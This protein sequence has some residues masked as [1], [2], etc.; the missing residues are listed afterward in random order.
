CRRRGEALAIEVWDTG[1][2]IAEADQRLIFEEFRRLGNGGQGLGLGLA[3]A[4]RIARLLGHR[5]SLRSTPGRG[6]CFAIAVPLAASAQRRPQ[7][8]G[9]APRAPRARV[10][11]VDNDPAVLKAMQAL[12]EGWH[13]EVLAARSPEEA[14]IAAVAAPPELLVLDYRLDG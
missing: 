2:G 11:V 7:A 13:C 9:T 5:L 4:E 14:V 3:I 8:G 12:L 6:T 10:L 1:P